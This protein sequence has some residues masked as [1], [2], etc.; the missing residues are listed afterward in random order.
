MDDSNYQASEDRLR[1]DKI[2][3]GAAQHTHYERPIFDWRCCYTLSKLSLESAKNK[4]RP[5]SSLNTRYRSRL[6]SPYFV[7]P[8]TTNTDSSSPDSRVPPASARVA[9]SCVDGSTNRRASGRFHLQPVDPGGDG[10]DHRASYWE[11]SFTLS[12]YLEEVYGLFITGDMLF[13][14]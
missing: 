10:V 6:P 1:K 8:T 13:K 4:R 3:L 2:S 11:A 7:I 5:S 9:C 12:Q 14:L